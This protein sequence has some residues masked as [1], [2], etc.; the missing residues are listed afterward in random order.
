MHLHQ[1]AGEKV[2]NLVE[3]LKGECYW[4]MEPAHE[5]GSRTWSITKRDFTVRVSMEQG[6]ASS[7]RICLDAVKKG[8]PEK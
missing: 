7:L 1:F 4:I 8:F 3:E 5:W 2:S 6:R